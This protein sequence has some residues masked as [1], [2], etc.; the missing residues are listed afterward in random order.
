M[1]SK[2]PTLAVEA[3][4]LITTFLEPPDLRSLHVVCREI[5]KKTL[6]SFGRTNFAT[7][8]TDLGLKNLQQL[9]NVANS[10]YLAKHVQCLEV[11]HRPDGIL[12]QGFQWP[13]DS[14]G[15]LAEDLNGADL[16]QRL[17]SQQLL[18]CR[19]FFIYS[20]DEYGPRHDTNHIVPSDAVGLILSIIASAGLAVHSFTVQ[21]NHHGN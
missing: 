19:S 5:S 9:E 4:E 18:K 12:G 20:Y 17:L 11:K 10:E 15:C 2:F 14:S 21:S 7:V 6:N 13:R 3:I 16:L 1:S 8:Q